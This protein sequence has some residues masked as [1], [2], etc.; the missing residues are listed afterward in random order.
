M[1]WNFLTLTGARDA[2][3]FETCLSK[4]EKLD[5][6]AH[7]VPKN[8]SRLVFTRRS[9]K[10]RENLPRLVREQKLTTNSVF[11]LISI[12]G[13]FTTLRF[14]ALAP[15]FQRDISAVSERYSADIYQ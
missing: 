14:P 15:G 12:R 13:F 10:H 1:L 2:I 7:S 6:K 5:P 9:A 11:D 3:S 8:L 4:T